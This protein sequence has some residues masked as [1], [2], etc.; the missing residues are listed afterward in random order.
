MGWGGGRGKEGG[1]RPSGPPH[2]KTPWK[3]RTR[4]RGEPFYPRHTQYN[5]RKNN[6]P[7]SYYDQVMGNCYLMGLGFVYFV[8]L[9]PSGYEVTVEP[10]DPCYTAQLVD[11]LQCYWHDEV[12]TAFEQRDELL[13]TNPGAVTFGWLPENACAA[14]TKRK[15]GD[16]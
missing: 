13:R 11:R 3:L 2:P 12:I 6:I 14:G 9:S 10:V 5:K 15:L 8:V 4:Q 16:D 1:G 7:G